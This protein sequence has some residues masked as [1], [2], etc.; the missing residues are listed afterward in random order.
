MIIR[1]PLQDDVILSLYHL[2][3]N[4]V[5]TFKSE[6]YYFPREVM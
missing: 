4:K 2:S 1:G 6:M 3:R 5:G